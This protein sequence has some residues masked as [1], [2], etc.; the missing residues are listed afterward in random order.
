MDAHLYSSPPP[1]CYSRPPYPCFCGTGIDSAAPRPTMTHSGTP[2]PAILTQT[3]D[4]AT[5]PDYIL[6]VILSYLHTSSP[7]SLPSF[8]LI[9]RAFTPHTRKY[10]HHSITLKSSSCTKDISRL[11]TLDSLLKVNPCLVEGTE[12][13]RLELGDGHRWIFSKILTPPFRTEDPN[14][15]NELRIRRTELDEVVC[16]ILLCIAG[17]PADRGCQGRPV[18][19][20]RG[21]G[22]YRTLRVFDLSHYT[23]YPVSPDPGL[24]RGW[25]SVLAMETLK[26]I[27][28]SDISDFPLA[29]LGYTGEG[30]QELG[31]LRVK[32]DRRDTEQAWTH[33][34]NTEA[35]LSPDNGEKRLRPRVLSVRDCYAETVQPLIACAMNP[36][37]FLDFSWVEDLTVHPCLAVQT[38]AYNRLAITVAS[39]S[40]KLD[41]LIWMSSS[42]HQV[43]DMDVLSAADFTRFKRVDLVFDEGFSGFPQLLSDIR[44]LLRAASDVFRTAPPSPNPEGIPVPDPFSRL[45]SNAMT[46]SSGLLSTTPVHRK[47]HV[48]SSL[49][50]LTL[51]FDL[52]NLTMQS[53]PESTMSCSDPTIGIQC[54]NGY[55]TVALENSADHHDS[56]NSAYFAHIK[57]IWK[58]DDMDMGVMREIDSM[59][60]SLPSHPDVA[61]NGARPGTNGFPYFK[62]LS[63]ICVFNPKSSF[64][65][66]ER[67]AM[68]VY[69]ACQEFVNRGLP[70]LRERG[71]LQFV[72]ETV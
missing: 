56:P 70:R 47:K 7:D 23:F 57:Y 46:S 4:W 19:F 68:D 29:L 13:L 1:R 64:L 72:I 8:A 17:H 18:S 36:T 28:L 12:R 66:D 2:D 10:I 26:V 30:V 11:H 50:E 34:G 21:A 38:P 63:T 43:N 58:L 44:D 9:S 27:H 52:E 33:T 3:R 48:I 40:E 39:Q 61:L 54:N 32:L 41:H 22:S 49:E 51:H 45:R 69:E 67:R 6:D 53:R 65:L 35:T 42:Q 25:Q 71:M 24:M 37:T 59:L 5:L 55:S 16:R 20:G 62:R 15:Y 31:L 60:A 14:S